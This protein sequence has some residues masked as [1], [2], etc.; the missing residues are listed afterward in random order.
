MIFRDK[1]NS[2]IS[3]FVIITL[4]FAIFSSCSS[5]TKLK[6]CNERIVEAVI[7][8]KNAKIHKIPHE[9]SFIQLESNKDC[10]LSKVRNIEITEKYIYILD[11]QGFFIFNKEGKFIKRIQKGRG[12]GELIQPLSFKIDSHRKEIVIA[13]NRGF[14]HIYTLEAEH[15]STY[16]LEK[17][18]GKEAIRISDNQFLLNIAINSTYWSHLILA[19][20]INDNCI[21][22]KY[23]S[24]E[25]LPMKNYS[26][27]FTDFVIRKDNI[28]FSNVMSRS[29]YKY[30]GEDFDTYY[31]IDFKSFE[32]PQSFFE[33]Y[34]KTFLFKEQCY[35]EGYIPFIEDYFPL[36]KFDFIGF[37]HKK[38]NCGIVY[39]NE[40]EKLYLT[41]FP[42]LFDLPN[43]KSFEKPCNANDNSLFFVYNND[44]LS[45]NEKQSE[46]AILEISNNKI[47]IRE[48]NNPLIVVV[49][50]KN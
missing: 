45:V 29:I 1:K 19:Y 13:E 20:N 38:Y 8:N 21:V 6:D 44:I 49:S 4:V 33:K 39:H 46:N 25:N 10:Y 5:K 17:C 22:A 30:N 35:K 31:T 15:I 41:T 47:Q 11:K 24:K 48:N 27:G 18:F 32:P 28:Y 26:T 7:D 14:I 37:S 36:N 12:P 2:I 16:R 42:D 43:T 9:I 40:P 3:I 34:D 23:I 50:I